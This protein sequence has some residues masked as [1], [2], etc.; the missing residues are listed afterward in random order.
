MNHE[1][2]DDLGERE[3]ESYPFLKEFFSKTKSSG[4]TAR[5][6]MKDFH[7]QLRGPSTVEEL[8]IEWDRLRIEIEK[9]C[10]RSDVEAGESEELF[11]ELSRK[12]A[13]CRTVLDLKKNQ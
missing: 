9:V 4:T 7:E 5:E 6:L 10:I 8:Q 2:P 12:I 3:I 13:V 11:L 1:M